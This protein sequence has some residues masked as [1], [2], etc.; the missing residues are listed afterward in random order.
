MIGEIGV[1]EVDP[2]LQVADDIRTVIH[3]VQKV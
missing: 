1:A 3:Q 2:V